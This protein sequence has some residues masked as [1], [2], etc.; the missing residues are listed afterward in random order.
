VSDDTPK[1]FVF[2]A[3]IRLDYT[4]AA[5]RHL[6][7]YLRAIAE[8]RIVGGRCSSCKKVYLPQ[9]GACPTCG[10]PVEDEVQVADVGTI[11]TFSV[12]R[13][14]FDA[15]PFPPPY[16]SIAV[17]LDGADM[18]IFHLLRGV[19]PE[20]A[21]MGMRVRAVWVPDNE[22]APTLASVRWF[23]PSGEP[24]VDFDRIASHL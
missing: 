4:I 20:E 18:P 9:R 8:K 19:A 10:I 13:I 16:I 6:T 2:Q 7:H 22:L 11:T 12:I 21:R 1:D 5:G 15:A 17:L 14:P 3:P 24:D 23:E